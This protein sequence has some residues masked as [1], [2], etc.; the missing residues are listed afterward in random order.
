MT[1]TTALALWQQPGALARVL[2]PEEG[3][4]TLAYVARLMQILPAPTEDVVDRI[5]AE[6]LYAGGPA[7]ENVFWDQET[8]SSKDCVGRR[9]IFRSV[10]AHPSDHAEGPFPFFLAVNVTDL[11]SGEDTILTTGSANI[12]TSL[13]KAQLL[14]ALPW[15]GQIVGPRRAPRSGHVPLHIRWM[16]RVIEQPDGAEAFDE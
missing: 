6:I 11:D 4:R 7:D 2:A 10:H 5:A 1:E 15:E 13:V 12:V 16:S 8:L 3:E 9:F 14:G